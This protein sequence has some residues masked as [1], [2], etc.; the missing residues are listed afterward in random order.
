MCDE[1]CSVNAAAHTQNLT[2]T[3][4]SHTCILTLHTELHFL[5]FSQRLHIFLL[6]EF[7]NVL[8]RE[9]EL[10]EVLPTIT[11]PKYSA[12]KAL[13]FHTAITSKHYGAAY[14]VKGENLSP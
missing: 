1:V 11:N 7:L 5:G 10:L 13:T 6:P 8:C 3:F 4:A 2:L 12:I 14:A 9:D